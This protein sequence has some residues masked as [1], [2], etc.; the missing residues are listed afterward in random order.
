MIAVFGIVKSWVGV[1]AVAVAAGFV[2][3]R[4]Q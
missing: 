2:G 3:F 1:V 4:S